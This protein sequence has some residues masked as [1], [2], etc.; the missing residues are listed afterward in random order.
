MRQAYAHEA[1]LALPPGAGERAPGAA[2]NP[3]TCTIVRG[4]IELPA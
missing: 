1:V 3:N 4:R 2:V